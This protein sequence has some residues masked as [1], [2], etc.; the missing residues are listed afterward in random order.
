M[1]VCSEMFKAFYR[2]CLGKENAQYYNVELLKKMLDWVLKHEPTDASAM[3]EYLTVEK[4]NK[5]GAREIL[6]GFYRYCK[7]QG[8]DIGE[9]CLD[10]YILIDENVLRALEILR[11]L[12][13][14]VPS[15][16]IMRLFCISDSTLTRTIRKLRDGI[17]FYGV[18]VKLKEGRV[19][20]G[21]YELE[22]TH[23]PFFLLLDGKSRYLVEDYMKTI[24]D[25]P[26]FGDEAEAILSKLDLQYSEDSMLAYGKRQSDGWGGESGS[27]D[28]FAY[29]ESLPFKKELKRMLTERCYAYISAMTD[30]ETIFNEKCR[31]VSYDYNQKKILLDFE[32]RG[33]RE[34]S[35]YDIADVNL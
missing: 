14:R 27:E 22:G 25:D 21:Y 3:E 26:L 2:S 20:K 19:R 31:A 16:E 33:Q 18:L 1:S 17:Y 35:L 30:Q 8:Y 7:R 4:S 6:R 24:R 9:S 10:E 29:S 23:I 5:N 12:L 34:L 15:E 11:F 13:G 28:C 32:D